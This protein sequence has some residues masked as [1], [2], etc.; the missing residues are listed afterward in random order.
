[1]N[2][3]KIIKN[4]L[5]TKLNWLKEVVDVEHKGEV[6]KYTSSS[7]LPSDI[8]EEY[9][10]TIKIDYSK[11]DY[12]GKCKLPRVS[13]ITNRWHLERFIGYAEFVCLGELLYYINLLTSS[14][15]KYEIKI[16][17]YDNLQDRPF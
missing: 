2:P 8:W 6:K 17:D 7:S 5:P 11:L 15:Y 4:L 1:M 14:N 10:I 12:S 9:E 13:T 3:T 16:V